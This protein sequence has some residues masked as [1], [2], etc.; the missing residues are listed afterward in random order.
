MISRHVPHRVPYRVSR[1]GFLGLL[2]GAGLAAAGCG[3]AGGFL[4]AE[5]S[6]ETLTSALPLPRPFTVPL[7]VPA[8]A[9][10]VRPGHYEV[11]QRAAKVEIVPGVLT[12]VWGYDGTFPGPTFDLRRGD[13]TV[14]RV[15]NELPVPTSTHLHGGVTPPGS[16]GY[17]TDLVVARG[18]GSA[19][20][21]GRTPTTTRRCGPSTPGP[22]TTSTRWTSGPPR[23]GTTTTAWTSPRRRCGAGWPGSSWSATTR[24]TPCRCRRA[25]GTSR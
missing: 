19:R 11:V 2:G 18:R 10:P 6:G 9:R 25:S 1:R 15:R 17:P 5:V 4:T 14:V 13:R 8:T 20:R 16:D 3:G 22:R 7:P 23:S 24:T 21:P 12:E